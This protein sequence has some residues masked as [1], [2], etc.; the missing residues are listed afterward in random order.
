LFQPSYT[1]NAGGAAR[2]ST[3]SWGSAVNGA[4]DVYSYNVDQF[5]WSHPDYLICFANGN[6]GAP[7][8]VGSPATAKDCVSV[9]GTRN[10]S[11]IGSPQNSIYT[12][13]SRGPAADNRR[14]P[15]VCAP[16]Q[17]LTSANQGPSSYATLAGTSMASPCVA[18][19]AALMRQY[20]TDGWY[21]TGTKVP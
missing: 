10:G 9:G 11:T 3:N 20:C 4:Y 18:G 15:T 13:T 21:P 6:S 19:M 8:T 7:N 17:S 12:S 16:A 2:I 1:G 5:M 14:K